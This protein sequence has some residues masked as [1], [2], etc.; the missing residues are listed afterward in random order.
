MLI[1]ASSA[2]SYRYSHS[3]QVNINACLT[4]VAAGTKAAAAAEPDAAALTSSVAAAA[5]EQ[6]WKSS[7]VK[8]VVTNGKSLGQICFQAFTYGEVIQVNGR[9]SNFSVLYQLLKFL[10]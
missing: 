3:F 9:H 8:A 7:N 2:A 5:A 1:Y 10:F 4:G 6:K